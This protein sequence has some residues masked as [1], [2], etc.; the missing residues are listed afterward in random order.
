MMIGGHHMQRIAM[1]LVLIGLV[2]TSASLGARLILN[3]TSLQ[4]PAQCAEAQTLIDDADWSA[5]QAAVGSLALLVIVGAL[6]HRQSVKESRA[7]QELAIDPQSTSE[8]FGRLFVVA[9][10]S[11]SLSM[12]VLS[13]SGSVHGLQSVALGD[14]VRLSL[15][16]GITFSLGMMGGS[17]AMLAV[18]IGF[19]N[20][21]PSVRPP[22]G[23][24]PKS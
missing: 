11:I 18:A 19:R 17:L 3:D 23:A 16:K 8:L 21:R 15:L 7:S 22:L 1:L 5:I 14:S 24:F 10:V 12:S 20:P 6:L 13:L 4:Q 9:A 2:G